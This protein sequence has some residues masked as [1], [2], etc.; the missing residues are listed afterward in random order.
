MLLEE[1]RTLG[2]TEEELSNLQFQVESICDRL[3]KEA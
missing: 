1:I 2:V 3:I